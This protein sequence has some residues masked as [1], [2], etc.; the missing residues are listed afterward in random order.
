MAALVCIGLTVFAGC[1][2]VDFFSTDSLLRAPKL[3]GQNAALQQ[4]FEQ[5]VGKDVF[6]VSPLTGAYRSAFILQDCNGDEV[7]EAFVFYA[8]NDTENTIHIHLLEFVE[9]TWRSVADTTGNGSEVYK[10]E[11]CSVDRD[12][13]PELAVTWTVSDSKRDKT[14]SLY[15]IDFRQGETGNEFNPLASVQ[16]FDYAMLDIDNDRQNELFY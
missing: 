10:V 1:N 8:M 15:K 6:L 5:T 12:A 13:A 2:I 7:E 14:L 3:T 9:G 4:A 16:I 11:F